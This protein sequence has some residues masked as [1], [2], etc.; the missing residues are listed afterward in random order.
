MHEMINWFKLRCLRAIQVG[1][2]LA[3]VTV[4][5]LPK[6]KHTSAASLANVGSVGSAELCVCVTLVQSELTVDGD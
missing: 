1:I 3:G 5:E 4:M 2:S 6:A